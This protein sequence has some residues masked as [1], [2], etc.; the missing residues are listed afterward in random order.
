MYRILIADDE[1]LTRNGIAEVI[2]RRCPRWE[3]DATSRDGK[4]ALLRAQVFLPH[5]VLTDITMPHMNGLEL[6]ENLH[7]I[8]PEA[9]LLILSGY[10]QFEYAIQALRLGVSDY[11]LKPL[12]TDKLVSTL[13]SL[14]NDLDVQAQQLEKARY[15]SSRAETAGLLELKSYFHSALR[16]TD[17]PQLSPAIQALAAGSSYCCVLCRGMQGQLELLNGLLEQRMAPSMHKLLLQLELPAKLG[18]VF[19][20]PPGEKSDSFVTLN[21]MLGS[22]AVQCKRTA[23]LDVQFFIGSMVNTPEMLKHSYRRSLV[24][25]D[26]AFPENTA[27]VTSY[28]DVLE[29]SLLPCKQI[30]EQL[31]R[32]IPTAVICGNRAAFFQGC[33][34]LFTWFCSE[35]IRDATYMRMCV[36]SLCYAI[37]RGAREKESIS[38]YEFTNFQMEIMAATSLKELRTLFESFAQLRWLRQEA[39]VPPRR[40]LTDRVEQIV[41]AQLSNSDFSLDNVAGVLYISPNYLRQLFKQETGQTFTEFLTAKRM[42]H[43]KMLLGIPKIRV[44]DVA[45]QCGYA[46]PRYFSVCFKKQFHMTPSEY[47]AS[48]PKQE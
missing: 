18:I 7:G 30:P 8:L 28:E 4:E 38:Y 16:G 23:G 17:L 42:Q 41:L 37:L 12:D 43:A 27:S 13:D 20:S 31:E 34:E 21:H 15:L 47:Q 44:S 40:T 48:L 46:D 1:A 11:L 32:D 35:G 45:E 19:W 25:R 36:V 6:L 24:A 26:Y 39:R 22:I 33:Q 2:R 29:S 3:V 10:D 9:K 14:A 5:A